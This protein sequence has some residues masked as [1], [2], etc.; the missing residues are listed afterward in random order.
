[1]SAKI[2]FILKIKI[3][4]LEITP[5]RKDIFKGLNTYKNHIFAKHNKINIGYAKIIGYHTDI[6]RRNKY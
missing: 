5:C 4:R 3:V 6:Q 2:Q 1:M